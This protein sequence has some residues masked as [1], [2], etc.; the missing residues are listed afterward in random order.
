MGELIL[1]YRCWVLWSKNYWVILIPTLI[2]IGNLGNSYSPVNPNRA[3]IVYIWLQY[4]VVKLF[5]FW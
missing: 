5:T 3:I 1:I 4:V 2:A